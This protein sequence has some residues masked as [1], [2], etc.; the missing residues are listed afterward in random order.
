MQEPSDE[1]IQK[2]T[3]A[4]DRLRG[5]GLDIGRLA[6]S[7]D[8]LNKTLSDRLTAKPDGPPITPLGSST[9]RP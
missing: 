8:Q 9:G 1:S 3:E 2:L 7:I 5:I 6:G 4:L